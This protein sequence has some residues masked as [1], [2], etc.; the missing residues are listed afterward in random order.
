MPT[1]WTEWERSQLAAVRAQE[2]R[3]NECISC[4]KCGSQWFVQL[5]VSRFKADHV[6]VVGQPVPDKPGAIPYKLL[7]CV[8]C[9]D[10]LEPHVTQAPRDVAGRDYNNFIDTLEGAHDQRKEVEEKKEPEE[11]DDEIQS[12]NV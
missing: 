2:A 1:S 4:P 11:K 3:D 7:M 6:L 8:R 5:D 12:Q 9:M 10:M